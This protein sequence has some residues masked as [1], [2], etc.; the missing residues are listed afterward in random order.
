MSKK[1]AFAFIVV[2]FIGGYIASELGVRYAFA[3]GDDKPKWQHGLMLRV[4]KGDEVD[5]TKETK[6]VGIE[7]FEDPHNGNVIYITE[8]GSIAVVKK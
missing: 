7:V 3:Q 6:R 5:F 1:I 2:A 4:R 8:N